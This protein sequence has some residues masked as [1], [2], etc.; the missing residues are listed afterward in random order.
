[1]IKNKNFI[2]NK[3][4]EYGFTKENIRILPLDVEAIGGIIGT[5]QNM[6]IRLDSSI[7]AIID[8]HHNL[9]GQRLYDALKA[10]GG[11]NG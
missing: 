1:M 5:N 7:A 8:D 3:A 11:L 9:I 2:L 6:T 4:L 10:G